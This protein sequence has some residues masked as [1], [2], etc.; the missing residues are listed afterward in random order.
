[1]LMA[2]VLALSFRKLDRLDVIRLALALA[3]ALAVMTF[4]DS[5]LNRL[6]SWVYEPILA[7]LCWSAITL[8]RDRPWVF[9]ER[10]GFVAR[11]A[12]LGILL[13]LLLAAGSRLANESA[14][15]APRREAFT[16]SVRQLNPN[17]EDLYVS[18]GSAF[19]LELL[20]PFDDLE[21]YRDLQFY[22]V[23]ADTR[24]GHNLRRLQHLGIDDIHQAIYRDPRVRVISE[25]RHNIIL[26]DFVRE[27]YGVDIVAERI[28]TFSTAVRPLF[29]V[30]R[31]SEAP[32]TD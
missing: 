32:A 30:Y 26:T 17:P 6:V 21:P 22:S 3:A 14:I 10:I 28:A 23:G 29:D 2:I 9:A 16:D 20:G 18:W 19:P 12:L 25:Q 24:G 11:A 4:V 27:R 31:F 13:S 8:G 7:F 1:M 5:Q 15:R